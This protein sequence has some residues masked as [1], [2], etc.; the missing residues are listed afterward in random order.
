MSH[1]GKTLD[2]L[3]QRIKDAIELYL[4]VVSGN[5]LTGHLEFVGVQKVRID[6]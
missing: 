2:E 6:V 1:A 3:N 4:E 5:D